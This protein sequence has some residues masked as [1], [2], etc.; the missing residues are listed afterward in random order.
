MDKEGLFNPNIDKV[1]SDWFPSTEEVEEACR[2]VFGKSTA[3]P[4]CRIDI[5]VLCNLNVFTCRLYVCK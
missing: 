3:Y 4:I 1:D 2:D 5:N